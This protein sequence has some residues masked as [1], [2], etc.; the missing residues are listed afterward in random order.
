M[1]NKALIHCSESH[2]ELN[3]AG[4]KSEDKRQT[5]LRTF[6]TL[7]RSVKIMTLTLYELLMVEMGCS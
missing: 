4:R 2:Q 6:N 3:I 5:S 7:C 1:F